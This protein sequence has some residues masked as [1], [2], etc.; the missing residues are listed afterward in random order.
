MT[1]ISK[2]ISTS[3]TNSKRL[4]KFL[5]FGKND[6]QEKNESAPF[7]I[8][9]N[10]VKDMVA[11]MVPSSEIG[12]EIVIGYINTNQLAGVGETRLFSTNES[13]VIQIA[14]HLKNDGTIEIGGNNDNLVRFTEL[15]AGFEQLKSDFNSLVNLYNL[16]VHAGTGVPTI[17]V[18]TPS[19]ASIN[20]SKINELK[21]S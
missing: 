11:I 12:R 4:V 8:D 3:I 16:H 17:S 9:S 7:G 13:G 6:V 18:S 21:C 10:P 15:K 20:A 14:I 19:T 2:V 1:T 5:G